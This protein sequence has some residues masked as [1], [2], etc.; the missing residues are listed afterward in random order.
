MKILKTKTYKELLNK[1]E[2]LEKTRDDYYARI[3]K[4]ENLKDILEKM[5]SMTI[6]GQGFSVSGGSWSTSFNIPDS[7]AEY[8]DDYCGGKVIKQE[9]NKVIEI[10]INGEIKTGLTKQPCDKGYKYKLIRQSNLT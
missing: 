1:I 8:V 7:F 5:S 10:T 4:A 6:N 9:A 3:I 2:H